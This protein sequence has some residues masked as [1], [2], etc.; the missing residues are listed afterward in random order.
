MEVAGQTCILKDK[1]RVNRKALEAV[2]EQCQLALQQ[3]G[4]DD[5]DDDD[6]DDDNEVVAP[7]DTIKTSAPLNSHA[8]P[9]EV[10]GLLKLR[11]EH[12]HSTMMLENAQVSPPENVAEG[13]SDSWDMVN[14]NDTW[15]PTNVDLD[16][17][18]YILVRQEDVKE[19]IASFMA[20]YLLSL[21]QAKDLTPNQLQEALS[22]T[23]STKKKK[24]KLRKAWDGTKVVYN[25]A[26][27]GAT[28]IGLYQNPVLS[29]AAS[30]AFW[31][32]SR[33]FSKLW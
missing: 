8:D 14:E 10:C 23:F 20:A 33:A 32:S 28:A 19:G 15:G 7:Q 22:K 9:V 31:T 6:D 2:L 3:L 17:H 11:S 13:E 21:E 30:V 5:D 26:S 29:S 12:A 16:S 1:V 4:Y 18:D 25:M 24:G 27:W